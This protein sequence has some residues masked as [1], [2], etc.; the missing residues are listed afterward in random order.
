M[1]D[2]CEELEAELARAHDFNYTLRKYV[3]QMLSD[4]QELREKIARKFDE[5]ARGTYDPDRKNGLG[6]QYSTK[7][8]ND[9][10]RKS[11]VENAR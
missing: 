9:E 8:Q 11:A 2:R 10:A 1:C 3:L 6:F 5:F 4:H 7:A